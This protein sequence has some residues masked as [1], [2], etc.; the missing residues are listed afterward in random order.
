MNYF[1]ITYVYCLIYRECFDQICVFQMTLSSILKD[2]SSSIFK[3]DL[4]FVFSS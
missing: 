1:V 4:F 2:F 3:K